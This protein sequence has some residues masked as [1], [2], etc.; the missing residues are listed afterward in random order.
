[1]GDPNDDTLKSAEELLQ[2]IHAEL[3]LMTQEVARARLPP[4]IFFNPAMLETAMHS[5]F[6]ECE[7]F[8]CETCTPR[9]HRLCTQWL[10]KKFRKTHAKRVASIPLL[11]S[12]SSLYTL[13]SRELIQGCMA[14][15]EGGYGAHDDNLVQQDDSNCGRSTTDSQDPA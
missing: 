13:S 14:A 4:P 6:V 9:Q 5:M 1:M 11:G 10:W 8:P 3:R 12:P 7:Y 15:L 2:L